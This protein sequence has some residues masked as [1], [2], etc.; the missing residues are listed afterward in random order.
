MNSKVNEDWW[1][2]LKTL[3]SSFLLLAYIVVNFILDKILW[4]Y[5]SPDEIENQVCL[6][7]SHAYAKTDFFQRYPQRLSCFWWSLGQQGV[8]E[9]GHFRGSTFWMRLRIMLMEEKTEQSTGRLRTEMKGHLRVPQAVVIF[10]AKS[11]SE[12]KVGNKK[13]HQILRKKINTMNH[14]S[15]S[16]EPSCFTKVWSEIDLFRRI[17]LETWWR[18]G[19]E[20][21]VRVSGRKY[22]WLFSQ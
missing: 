9:V 3:E 19:A 8:S 16:E 10:I 14:L 1:F 22:M 15:C 20:A 4:S 6:H 12:I 5:Q 2:I 13:G 11:I 7:I 18:K 17:I 21:G